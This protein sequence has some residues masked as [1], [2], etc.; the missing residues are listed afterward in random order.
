MFINKN[1]VI[2]QMINSSQSPVT[3]R[4]S[5]NYMECCLHQKPEILNVDLG[6]PI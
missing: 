3:L 5:I 1:G 2:R 6:I 4:R